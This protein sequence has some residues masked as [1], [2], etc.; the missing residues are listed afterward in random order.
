[1]PSDK[2]FVINSSHGDAQCMLITYSITHDDNFSFFQHF[3]L[4]VINAHFME[5]FEENYDEPSIQRSPENK[6]RLVCPT[7]SDGRPTLPQKPEPATTKMLITTNIIIW[8]L[9]FHL[10]AG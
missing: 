10:W 9:Q 5:R 6:L 4:I 2:A 8:N 3:V 7:S 1:L